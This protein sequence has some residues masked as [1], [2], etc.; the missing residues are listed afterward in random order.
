MPI[1]VAQ[2]PGLDQPAELRMRRLATGSKPKAS[3]LQA[4]LLV[5]WCTLHRVKQYRRMMNSRLD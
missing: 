1:T 2:A 5:V 3:P 4:L